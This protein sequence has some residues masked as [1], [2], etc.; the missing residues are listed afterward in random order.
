MAAYTTDDLLTTVKNRGMLPDASTGSLSSAT[1]LQFG[2]EEL[3][4]PLVTLI[5]SAREKYY[6]TYSDT[7]VTAAQAVYAI[8]DRAVGGVLS[9]V[10]YFYQNQVMALIP[11]DPSSITTTNTSIYP[12]GFYFQ[13]NSIVLYPTP[14]TTQGTLRQRYF[15][16]PSRLDLVTNCALITAFDPIALTVT[17][18]SVPTSWATG[19]ICDFVPKSLP[20]TPYG[21]NT[22]LSG[23]TGTTISLVALPTGIAVGDY[24]ATAGMTP[25]PEIPYE[26]FQVLAQMVVCKALEAIGD[27]QNLQFAQSNMKSYMDSALRTITPR[28][29]TGPKKVVSGWRNF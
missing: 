16:R 22:A 1:L 6:E 25:I 5:L 8:P 2:S 11:I 3:Q 26:F 14:N 19:T 10:Q 15:Q 9:A 29:Q 17:V 18:A 27:A 12:Y 7:N 20:Y 21:L 24:I 28:D 4:G 23:V 13:N